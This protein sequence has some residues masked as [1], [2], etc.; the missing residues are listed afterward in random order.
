MSEETKGEIDVPDIPDS[1][2][3]QGAD[4]KDRESG[5][6]F[7]DWWSFTVS[8]LAFVISAS[9]FYINTLVETDDVRLIL[10]S[11]ENRAYLDYDNDSGFIKLQNAGDAV[12]V[13]AGNRTT[14]ISGY[15]HMGMAGRDTKPKDCQANGRLFM[16]AEDNF[17]PL[18]IRPGEAS[19]VKIE[20]T[21]L[22]GMFTNHVKKGDVITVCIRF[23]IATPT[24]QLPPVDVVLATNSISDQDKDGNFI[25]ASR[26]NDFYSAKGVR[27]IKLVRGS[28]LHGG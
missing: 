11:T 21:I 26:N 27:A 18:V 23:Y 9:G 1:A 13:N 14:V 16:S 2:E 8:T 10:P 22:P 3:T 5:K 20:D 4:K 7:R 28:H 12:L 24:E 19:V 6:S 25:F 15:D 17:K